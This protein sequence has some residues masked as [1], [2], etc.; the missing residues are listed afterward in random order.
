MQTISNASPSL[1]T[2]LWLPD[3]F[4]LFKVPALYLSNT[5]IVFQALNGSLGGAIWLEVA[6]EVGESPQHIALLQLSIKYS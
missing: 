2:L 3:H 6:V 5:R 4:G 1:F